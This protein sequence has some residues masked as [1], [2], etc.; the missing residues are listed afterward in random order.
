MSTYTKAEFEALPPLLTKKE[1]M[2]ATGLG[3]RAVD[4][5]TAEGKLARWPAS[6]RKGKFAKSAAAG[7]R[8]RA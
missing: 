3:W 5:L 1:F 8:G 7:I 6:S 4:R 2:A